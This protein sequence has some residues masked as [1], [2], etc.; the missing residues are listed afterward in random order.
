MQLTTEVRYPNWHAIMANTAGITYEILGVGRRRFPFTKICLGRCALLDPALREEVALTPQFWL[1]RIA[2]K[3]RQ[4][5][6]D[7]L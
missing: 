1:L 6:P 7:P 2:R 4:Q 3:R 5:P